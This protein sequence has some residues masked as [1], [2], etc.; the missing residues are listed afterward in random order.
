[1]T[2]SV[3]WR[4]GEY[5]KH[6]WDVT[7]NIRK[8]LVV[9]PALFLGVAFTSV[10]SAAQ[11]Y[12]SGNIGAVQLMDSDSTATAPGGS[13]TGEF[14]FDAGLGVNA[15]VGLS[16]GALRLEGELSY[17]QS[18]FDQ[19][20]LSS[21]TAGNT[22]FSFS[23]ATGD[24]GGDVTSLGVMGNMWYDFDMGGKLKP[25]IGGGIG[26]AQVEADIDSIAGIPVSLSGDD[27][28][29]AYQVGAGVGYDVS[30]KVVVTLGYR[31]FGT[32]DPEFESG[33]TTVEGEYQSHNIEIGMR[34]KF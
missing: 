9:L 19:G 34:F 27:T 21:L 18:D 3:F 14:E 10:P 2:D 11:Y 6:G 4:L 5:F 13:I 25:F 31:F 16:L 29:F 30:D 20:T 32:A 23:G 28:V 26:M 22:T 24:V 1:M 33:S 17:R 15:A 8:L 7:M 12:V